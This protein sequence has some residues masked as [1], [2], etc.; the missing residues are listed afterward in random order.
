MKKAFVALCSASML[1][2]C[3]MLM[4]VTVLAGNRDC[5]HNSYI[6]DAY[7]DPNT[8]TA[9]N[10]HQYKKG[11]GVN[12]PIY[13]T[14]YVTACYGNRYPQCAVCG[15]VDYSHP[16]QVVLYNDHA[17]CGLGIIVY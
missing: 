15:D 6:V 7:L 17:N 10:S 14:C 13:G 16:H 2:V 8:W 11:N 3:S 12:G 1:F 5:G 9:T 4:P